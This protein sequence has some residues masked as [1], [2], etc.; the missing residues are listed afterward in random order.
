M[1]ISTRDQVALD[2][3]TTA[4]WLNV[5]TAAI[6]PELSPEHAIMTTLARHLERVESGLVVDDKPLRFADVLDRWPDSWKGARYPRA[7]LLQ[8]TSRERDAVQDTPV[9]DVDDVT[10]ERVDVISDDDKWALFQSGEDTGEGA[11]AVFANYHPQAEALAEAVRQ[12]LAGDLS[13]AF[14]AWL[15]LPEA[16]L[17]APFRA[18]TAVGAVSILGGSS[19]ANLAGDMTANV[20]RV[21]VRFAWQAPR[22]VA[23][24]R[25]PDLKP[26]PTTTIEP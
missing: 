15:P 9:R 21:D 22:L 14:R 25:I 2:R 19:R 18:R 6:A 26:Q 24:A 23:R 20:W 11:V 1:A 10:G 12:S 13:R 17:P 7:V 8:A 5:A 3:A 4:G 16:A